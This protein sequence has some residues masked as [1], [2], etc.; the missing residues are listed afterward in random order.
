MCEPLGLEALVYVKQK[1]DMEG[2]MCHGS[3]N[4][5]LQDRQGRD[6]N[7]MRGCLNLGVGTGR[8]SIRVQGNVL[9]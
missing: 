7:Q 1:P 9:R 4:M 2:R 3:I 5:T 6:R 8:A